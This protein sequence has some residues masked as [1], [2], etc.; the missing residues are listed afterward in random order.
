[1]ANKYVNKIV[2]GTEVKLDLSADTIV[3]S[4][5]KKGGHRARQ[6]WRADC[7]LE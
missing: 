1:M 4:D 7:G 5:L 2:V 6:V 3:S